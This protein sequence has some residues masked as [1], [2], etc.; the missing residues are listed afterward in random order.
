M[1]QDGRAGRDLEE[2]KEWC[3]D[4]FEEVGSRVDPSLAPAPDRETREHV[5]GLDTDAI[6]ENDAPEVNER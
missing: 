1:T 6:R 4:Y 2:A 5:G 3:R